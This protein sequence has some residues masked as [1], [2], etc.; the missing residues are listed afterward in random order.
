MADFNTIKTKENLLKA[1][2]NENQERNRYKFSTSAAKNND[3]LF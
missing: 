1:F 3:T 2:T